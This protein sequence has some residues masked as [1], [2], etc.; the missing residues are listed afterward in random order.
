MVWALWGLVPMTRP[1]LTTLALLALTAALSA[2]L[3]HAQGS[4]ETERPPYRIDLLPG[5]NL[6]SFPGDPVD[7]A[8]ES[9][10]GPDLQADIILTYL[11]D[12]WLTALRDTEGRVSGTLTTILGGWGY[13][14]HTPVAETIEVTLAP[15]DVQP[16][17]RT[18][19]GWN[20]M[21]VWDTEQRLPGT[22]VAAD[23]YFSQIPWRVAY[24]F[25]TD[26]NRWAKHLPLS[27]GTV[28]IGAGYWVWA[29]THVYCPP[30]STTQIRRGAGT[31]VETGAGYRVQTSGGLAWLCP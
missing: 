4:A 26:A 22:E 30:V 24:S 21:G 31:A 7:T 14:V 5:W 29:T 3:L 9:V 16:V 18:I 1:L 20:L 19:Y 27:E 6:I 11:S 12:A 8:L 15:S 17:Q 25:N 2:G 28:E 13:W 23:D 10:M